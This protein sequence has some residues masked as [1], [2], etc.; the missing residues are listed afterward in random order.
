MRLK[1]SEASFSVSEI[2]LEGFDHTE[3]QK[4]IDENLT[5]HHVII[6]ED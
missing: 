3:R 1:P 5:M 6:E 4:I 2:P